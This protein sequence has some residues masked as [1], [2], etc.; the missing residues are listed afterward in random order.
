M[1]ENI[2][3]HKMFSGFEVEADRPSLT[4]AQIKQFVKRYPD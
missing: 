1:V 2:T 3:L 4:Q